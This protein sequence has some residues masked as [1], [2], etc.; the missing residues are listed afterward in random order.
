MADSYWDDV[1][2]R[3]PLDSNFTDVS[4]SEHTVTAKGDASITTSEKKFGAGSLALDAASEGAGDFL[5]IPAHSDWNLSS[6][7]FTFEMWAYPNVIGGSYN[8]TLLLVGDIGQAAC[9]QIAISKDGLPVLA[10]NSGNNWSWPVSQQIW[11]EDAL[12]TGQWYHIAAVINRSAATDIATLYIDGVAA[13]SGTNV[14]INSQAKAVHIGSYGWNASSYPNG[15]YTF[16]G[17]IDDVRITKA[18][19]YTANFSVPT[20]AYPVGAWA[21]VSTFRKYID[22]QDMSGLSAPANL[23][24]IHVMSSSLNLKSALHITGSGTYALDVATGNG[25]IRADEFVTYS[26]VEL[27]TNIQPLEQSLKTIIQLNPVSYSKKKTGKKEI[28]FIA[29]EVAKLI[30]EVCALD[31][32][33]KG[34]GIDYSRLSALIAEAIK[35]QQVQIKTQKDKI[36]LIKEIITKLQK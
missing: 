18:A 3:L 9:L 2:L 16:D 10:L 24:S 15:V 25:A 19:R 35:A 33:G 17:Y 31:E 4:N 22:L 23:G 32:A 6:G 36:T 14:S 13:A 28:G 12:S 30:P 29:Q 26:D 27:K 34:R 11:G 7:D 5:T 20:S 21:D 1:I 8:E